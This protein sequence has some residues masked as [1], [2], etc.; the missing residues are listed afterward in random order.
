[1]F[2][3][4]TIRGNIRGQQLIFD[5]FLN[6]A[7][8]WHHQLAI[9]NTGF[10][11]MS[12]DSDITYFMGYRDRS[13]VGIVNANIGAVSYRDRQRRIVS[14]SDRRPIVLRTGLLVTFSAVFRFQWRCP[15]WMLR[16][17]QESHR[18]FHWYKTNKIKLNYISAL[19]KT[20]SYRRYCQLG[21]P[22]K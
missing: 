18:H 6:P 8:F 4:L 3:T 16:P 9:I 21:L 17:D 10:L 14:R 12:R 13:P 2:D 15:S 20:Y 22:M 11:M 19:I 7:E 1:M 5:I